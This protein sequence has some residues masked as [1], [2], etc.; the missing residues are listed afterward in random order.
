MRKTSLTMLTILIIT[1]AMAFAQNSS[2]TSSKGFV[3]TA[4]EITVQDDNG[5]GFII[6]NTTTGE[7]KV[8]FCEYDYAFSGFGK[9]EVLGCNIYFSDI[10]DGYRMFASVSMCKQ[11]GKVSCEVFDGPDMPKID[12]ISELWT[13]VNLKDNTSQ[14]W[15]SPK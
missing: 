6:I 9:V 11:Q 3:G 12:P 2:P 4:K 15:K 5:K 1:T 10:Q 7:Y 13:D 14:C 8:V